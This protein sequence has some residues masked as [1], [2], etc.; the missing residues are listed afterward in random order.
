MLRLFDAHCHLQDERFGCNAAKV[1]QEAQSAGV[2]KLA[3]NGCWEGDWEKVLNIAREHEAVIPNF[4]LHPW[5]VK[6]RTS[7][8]LNKLREQLLAHPEAG[9]G[10]CGLDHAKA[11]T[12]GHEVQAEVFSQQLHLGSQLRRPVSVHCVKAFGAL[13]DIVHKAGPFPAGLVLHSWAGSA[14]V[15]RQLARIEGVYFSISGHTFN[16][17]DKK[18][19][20]MLQQ[21][22]LDRL[23]LE[24]DSPDGLLPLQK[25]EISKQK[26][27]TTDDPDE[28]ETLNKPANV[29]AVLTLVSSIM[30]AEEDRV[31]ESAFRNAC[32]VFGVSA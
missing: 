20:P 10:E 17:S 3:C 13:S 18:L 7:G 24:T 12:A 32:K 16:L 1:I 23:L 6:D 8:W 11:G 9:L 21:V 26:T 28:N 2:Q 25:R 5:W 15:T 29:R 22:P 4:G 30:H 14:E 27:V 19:T 31:A